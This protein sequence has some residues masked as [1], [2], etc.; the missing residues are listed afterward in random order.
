MKPD[1]DVI[2]RMG[3]LALSHAEMGMTRGARNHWNRCATMLRD[4]P[5]DAPVHRRLWRSV[6]AHLVRAWLDLGSGADAAAV[7]LDVPEACIQRGHRRVFHAAE[8]RCYAALAQR[9]GHEIER[10][11]LGAELYP[12]SWPLDQ[13]WGREHAPDTRSFPARLV[14]LHCERWL[15][16]FGHRT[17]VTYVLA[18]RVV[19]LPLPAFVDKGRL[20]VVVLDNDGNVV[21]CKPIPAARRY[22]VVSRTATKLRPALHK[23]WSDYLR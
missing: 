23:M 6:T 5:S 16:R 15:V 13:R 2:C 4:I 10:D 19:S 8:V 7:L 3:A 14:D 20:F 17:R 21:A 11:L 18:E 22:E 12:E 9:P 1:A